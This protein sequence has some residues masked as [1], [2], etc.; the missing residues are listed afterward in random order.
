MK[1]R[2]TQLRKVRRKLKEENLRFLRMLSILCGPGLESSGSFSCLVSP[3]CSWQVSTICLCRTISDGSLM[4][5][6]KRIMREKV[7]LS[8]C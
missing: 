2:K 3:S 7:V 5:S 4:H 1:A 6:Q 8:N